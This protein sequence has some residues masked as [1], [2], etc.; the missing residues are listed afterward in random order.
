MASLQ[1]D[2]LFQEA[3]QVP[4]EPPPLAGRRRVARRHI[5]RPTAMNRAAQRTPE[6]VTE[7]QILLFRLYS[8]D[9]FQA[10]FGR[11][12]DFRNP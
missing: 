12:N 3:A 4:L 1:P 8:P 7:A 10:H 2:R 9:A 5:E 11:Q 6:Q